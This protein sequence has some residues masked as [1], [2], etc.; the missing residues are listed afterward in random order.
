MYTPRV[1]PRHLRLERNDAQKSEHGPAILNLVE[2][3]LEIQLNN[4]PPRVNAI[5]VS[6]PHG[7]WREIV[8]T[9]F[10]ME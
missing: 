3:L 10:S 6:P 9:I 4:C 1:K 8:G 7:F 5:T 2:I